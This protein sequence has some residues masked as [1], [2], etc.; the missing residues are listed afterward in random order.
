M[1]AQRWR[2]RTSTIG[3]LGGYFA[4]GPNQRDAAVATAQ[5][6]E[7]RAGGLSSKNGGDTFLHFVLWFLK[8]ACDQI[9]GAQ[10]AAEFGPEF[11]LQGSHG[12][13][14]RVGRLIQVV[15]CVAAAERFITGHRLAACAAPSGEWNSEQRCHAGV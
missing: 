7:P 15:A 14:S 6:I 12:K 5:L 11:R 13:P 2:R 10:P 1:L 3:Q 4:D 9:V 8:L